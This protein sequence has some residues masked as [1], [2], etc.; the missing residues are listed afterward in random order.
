M[1]HKN[2]WSLNDTRKKVHDDIYSMNDTKINRY[3]CV[4]NERHSKRCSLWMKHNIHVVCEW[5]AKHI[6][7]E[8]H[9]KTYS[10]W[11]TH[12]SPV[13]CGWQI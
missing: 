10:L 11:M 2:I 7:C 1:I 13:L 12:K 4:V 3:R 9:I 8:C 6:I 5:H